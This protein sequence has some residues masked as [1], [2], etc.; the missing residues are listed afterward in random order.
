MVDVLN[1]P[2]KWQFKHTCSCGAELVCYQ[3]DLKVGSFGA[4]YGGDTPERL[5]Y[6]ECP[7]C[8]K[9]ITLS[10]SRV[11]RNLAG[12]NRSQLDNNDFTR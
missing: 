10:W 2:A 9:E 6:F 12:K 8:A 1:Q 5:P 3:E 4:N 7:C 11:P